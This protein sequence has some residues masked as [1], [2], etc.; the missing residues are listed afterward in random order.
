MVF[1]MDTINYIWVTISACF[2][3]FMQA[4]FICYEVGFVQA[5]NAVSVAIENILS[6]IITTLV[7]CTVGF[8][9]M[10]G[11]S[12]H[13]LAGAD[14]WFLNNLD[15]SANS[16]KFAFVFFQ[17]MFAGT[18]VTI[19]AGS[20]SERTKLTTLLLAAIVMAG[21]I[22]PLFGHWVWGGNFTAQEVWLEKL[23]FMDFAGAT[24]VHATAGWFA[25]AGII[26]VGRRHSVYTAEGKFQKIGRSNIPFA[27]LGTFILWF[28]WFG[29][30][31][32]SLL[33]FDL[34]IGQILLNTN[35]AA[36]SGV[37]GAVLTSRLC[38]RKKNYLEAIFSGALGGLVAI[39]AGSNILSFLDSLLVGFISG[40][41]VILSTNLLE[42]L[43][44]D[45]AVGAVPIHA[46]CG[47][48]GTILLAVLA[49]PEY[50]ATGSNIAQ[51]KI[52]IGVVIVNFLWSFI[53]G[54][55]TFYLLNK[56]I[57]L[58]VTLEEEKK[59]L[60]IVEFDDIYSWADFLKT[61]RYED[62]TKNLNTKIHEQNIML[63]K[64]ARLLVATQEQERLKVGRDF[65]DGVGQS[66]ATVKLKLGLL[67]EKIHKGSPKDLEKEVADAFYLV[68][69]TIEEMRNILQN[70]S[71]AMLKEKGLSNTIVSFAD[72]I[73]KT[74][75][76]SV[77]LHFS[78]AL[79]S[80][81]EAVELN[82]FRIIQES[83]ANILKHAVATKVHFVFRVSSPN[84]YLF[85]I[86]DNGKGF[87]RDDTTEGIGFNSMRE[88]AGMIGGVLV[89]ESEADKGTTI[90]LEVPYEKD[91]RIDS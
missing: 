74:T 55:I 4:G 47:A 78:E 36:A 58:R 67:K 54:L 8:A 18:A 57:G 30:N 7:F 84:V 70:L 13:G 12:L 22:Y 76:I 17:L 33:K 39:T 11:P 15:I 80:W 88:R 31:G 5:K 89:I 71:P 90:Y 64:Q 52:Q 26:I 86:T 69:S 53:G 24:V 28:S 32:G 87:N 63:K 42:Q 66:L 21:V 49:K 3:F 46:F 40:C 65:H 68:D 91:T 82:I 50:L 45:D 20:M 44:L 37:V 2:V 77:V 23:G 27:A 43:G 61:A 60:N 1:E 59:G 48:T 10:F 6:F 56:T 16:L 41:V 29:F 14:Y 62:I 73:E 85:K 51:L 81:E 9:L 19:F 72:S 75:G 38:L 25:L 83:I 79:P 35:F 34:R